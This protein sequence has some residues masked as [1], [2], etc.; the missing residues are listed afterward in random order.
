MA[1]V[2]I[3]SFDGADKGSMDLAADVFEAPQNQILVREVLNAYN[4][5]QRQGTHSTKTRA[6]VSGGGKK[7]WAQKG[8]GNARQ[9]STRSP[10]WRHGAIVFG[11]LPRDYR[12]KTNRRKR[13]GALRA[14]LSVRLSEGRLII[15]DSLHVAEPKTKAVLAALDNLGAVGR[16]YIVTKEVNE[17]LLRSTRNTLHVRTNVCNAISVYDLILADTIVMT[18]DAAEEIQ[19]TLSTTKE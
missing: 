8:T 17:N 14:L 12:E 18:K 4:Q 11:P 10:Q 13:R 1:S 6:F 7:P 19:S 2:A 15:V 9:G 3:K 16:V 5:N